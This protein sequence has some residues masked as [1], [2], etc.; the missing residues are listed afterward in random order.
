MTVINS[1]NKSVGGGTVPATTCAHRRRSVEI[2]RYITEK[3]YIPESMTIYIHINNT[4]YYLLTTLGVY[5]FI[6]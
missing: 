3:V 4:K 5:C 6:L 1:G 2:V